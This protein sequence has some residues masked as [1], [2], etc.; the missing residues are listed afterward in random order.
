MK[1]IYM[2]TG[3]IVDVEG[4]SESGVFTRVSFNGS[5]QFVATGQLSALP[6]QVESK[7]LREP[8]SPTTKA[9]AEPK[10]RSSSDDV[11]MFLRE[12]GTEEDLRNVCK[13][14]GIEYP[15][16]SSMGLTKMAI[17][18]QLRKLIKN[19]EYELEWA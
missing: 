17:G 9:K 19:G 3:E 10:A 11:S 15:Q 1:A 7:I 5:S 8:I 16:R 4:P 12:M 14:V 6:E 18:N 13:D 2:P